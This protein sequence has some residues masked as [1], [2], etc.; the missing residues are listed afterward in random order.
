MLKLEWSSHVLE[1]PHDAYTILSQNLIG[2]PTENKEK[3]P[4]IFLLLYLVILI[5]LGKFFYI[6]CKTEKRENKKKTLNNKLPNLF[7]GII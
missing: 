6:Q 7:V 5:I 2:R 4:F 3:Q 1:I